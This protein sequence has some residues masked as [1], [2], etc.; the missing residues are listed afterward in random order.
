MASLIF[1][2]ID[3]EV[4]VILTYMNSY[5]ITSD[6]YTRPSNTNTKN[7]DPTQN[8]NNNNNNNNS[9]N[10]NNNN[11]NSNNDNSNDDNS[12]NSNNNNNDNNDVDT[13]TTN[14]NNNDNNNN[15]NDFN[16]KITLFQ[17]I[18]ENLTKKMTYFFFTIFGVLLPPKVFYA[19][20]G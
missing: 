18:T 13:T 6:L 3:I 12:N 7:N 5:F 19:I 1:L 8:N 14:N 2:I 9:N 10:N 20:H 4:I 11:N 15:N 17:N 16:N